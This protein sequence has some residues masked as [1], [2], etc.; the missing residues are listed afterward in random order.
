MSP[1]PPKRER[2]VFPDTGL[3]FDPAC[4]P[5]RIAMLRWISCDRI[6][7]P[8]ED[9]ATWS[10]SKARK[11]HATRE[12]DVGR[13]GD[14]ALT[15]GRD[16]REGKPPDGNG[17][18]HDSHVTDGSNLDHVMCEICAAKVECAKASP[19]FARMD[20]H[21]RVR[22]APPLPLAGEGR[23]GGRSGFTTKAPVVRVA[24]QLPPP[25]P[26]PARGGGSPLSL[27][28]GRISTLHG[29]VPR[30]SLAGEKTTRRVCEAAAPFQPSP[31][32]QRGREESRAVE[33]DCAAGRG[34]AGRRLRSGG[35][36]Y[37]AMAS[38]ES[39]ACDDVTDPKMPPCA[40]I[41]ASPASWKCGK[42]EAQQSESTMQR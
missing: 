39:S 21:G 3:L 37:A 18:R 32:S 41:I 42:Y 11:E 12:R 24:R 27:V 6:R 5:R 8:N 15:D 9:R 7:G 19:V 28:R 4:W 26:S 25:Q 36:D 1:S 17:L 14:A 20:F 40:L 30:K 22:L 16:G 23:G 2:A 13:V 33:E 10:G 34:R 35:K 31:A 29:V 38:A